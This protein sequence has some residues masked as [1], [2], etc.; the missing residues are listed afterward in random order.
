MIPSSPGEELGDIFKSTLFILPGVI[1][2]R[3]KGVIFW[4]AG[5]GI[6]WS[7][8]MWR[9]GFLG[10]LYWELVPLDGCKVVI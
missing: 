3:S 10:L 9:L 2:E 8:H 5:D 7:I 4:G 6:T 1:A